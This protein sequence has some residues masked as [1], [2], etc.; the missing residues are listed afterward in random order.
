MT[1]FD[2]IARLERELLR[3]GVRARATE[4][5]TCCD[6]GRT[7]LVGERMYRYGGEGRVCELCRT[8]HGEA[9]QAS[10]PIR[11]AELGRTVRIAAQAA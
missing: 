8:G 9:P 2:D 4:D 1:T 5:R 11:H 7:P 10:E 3:R 6:C